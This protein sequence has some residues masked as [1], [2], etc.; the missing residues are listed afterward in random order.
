MEIEIIIK[1]PEQKIL[2]S[3]WWKEEEKRIKIKVNKD[4]DIEIKNEDE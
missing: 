4:W 3:D 1:I 2:T